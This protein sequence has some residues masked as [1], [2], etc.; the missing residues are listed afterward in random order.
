MGIF[1]KTEEDRDRIETLLAREKEMLGRAKSR[2]Q[3]ITAAALEFDAADRSYYLAA[4]KAKSPDDPEYLKASAAKSKAEAKVKFL[5]A[6]LAGDSAALAEA[7]AERQRIG[8]AQYIKTFTRLTKA[9]EATAAKLANIIT[10]YVQTTLELYTESAKLQAASPIGPLDPGTLTSP[11]A[12]SKL[13]SLEM[14]RLNPVVL[15]R[16]GSGVPGQATGALLNP[17]K[18]EPLI[19]ALKAADAYLLRKLTE[20][21]QARL[22]EPVASEEASIAQQAGAV[23]EPTPA[24]PKTQTEFEIRASIPKQKLSV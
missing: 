3:E 16:L 24:A 14:T 21:P 10:A 20:A 6:A 1:S 12:L 13:I 7:Q 5:E 22:R 17:K 2:E 9:R 4:A 23:A 11:A 8:R 15:T 19:E 18:I